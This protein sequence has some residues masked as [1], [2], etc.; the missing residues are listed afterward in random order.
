LFVYGPR[1]QRVQPG[2]PPRLR[3]HRRPLEESEI[4]APNVYLPYVSEAE[5]AANRKM[6]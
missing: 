2:D 3:S 4:V 6:L 5:Y 1:V